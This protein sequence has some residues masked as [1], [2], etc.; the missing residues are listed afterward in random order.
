MSPSLD[1]SPSLTALDQDSTLVAVIEM[2]QT[3]WLI[4][5]TVPGFE[6]N[7]LKKLDADPDSVFSLL[8]RWRKEAIQAGREVR[9]IVVAYE[10]GR[11]YRTA[12]ARLS[13]LAA[14][15][16]GPLQHGSHPNHQ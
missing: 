16:E 14:G 13:W 3:K 12:D 7:P 4:A 8:R 10:A 11:R 15:R 1:A 5:A 6:R 9:R 2:S